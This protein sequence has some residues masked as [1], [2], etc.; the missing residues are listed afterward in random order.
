MIVPISKHWNVDQA[1]GYPGERIYIAK[2][3]SR[4]SEIAPL[5][6]K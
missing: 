3:H 6:H 2:P 4:K 5:P 1:F